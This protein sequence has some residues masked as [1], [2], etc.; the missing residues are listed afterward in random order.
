MVPETVPSSSSAITLE[1]APTETTTKPRPE[2]TIIR[3][4]EAPEWLVRGA[5][6]MNKNELADW[7]FTG[8][9]SFLARYSELRSA[10]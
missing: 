4:D 1:G 5:E 8:R 6:K 7:I 10:K 2:D 3:H 9:R